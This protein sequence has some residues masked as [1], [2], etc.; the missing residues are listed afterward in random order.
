[1]RRVE[2]TIEINTWAKAMKTFSSALFDTVM[3][4]A[5][6]CPTPSQMIQNTQLLPNT[7][8]RLLLPVLLA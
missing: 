4:V 5:K 2:E 8:H 1:M 6:W 7:K 3:P